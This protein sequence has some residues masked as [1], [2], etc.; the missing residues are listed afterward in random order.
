MA[1][2]SKYTLY[3]FSYVFWRLLLATIFFFSDSWFWILDFE[4]CFFSGTL[5]VKEI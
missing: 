1:Y 5:K 2:N 4:F 3:S